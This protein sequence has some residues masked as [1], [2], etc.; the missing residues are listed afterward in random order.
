M[1][2]IEGPRLSASQRKTA[3][4]RITTY[5]D[6]D[7]LEELK[8]LSQQSGGKYQSLLNQLLRNTLQKEGGILSRLQ[9][10]EKAVFKAG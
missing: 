7:L 10:L 1:H 4:V 8:K 3:K 2:R 5:L 9:R 6:A